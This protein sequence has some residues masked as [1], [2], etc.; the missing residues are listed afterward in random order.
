MRRYESDPRVDGLPGGEGVFLPCSFWLADN[1]ALMGR[2]GDAAALFER[3]VGLCN[4]VGL[5][6]EEYDVSA[7]RLVGNFPQA[8][9][10][11]SLDQQRPQLAPASAR[12][13][14]RACGGPWASPP[15][16]WRIDPYAAARRADAHSST[17]ASLAHGARTA[18]RPLFPPWSDTVFR[19]G[20]VAA[21][22]GVR[23]S[24][25]R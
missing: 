3:L 22:L 11:V 15:P 6:S 14:Q 21:V 23:R 12:T 8:F 5:L 13:H 25:Y 19:V 9:S 18:M 4:D 1:W 24:R 16:A 2:H 7:G 20:L 10:H 17:G